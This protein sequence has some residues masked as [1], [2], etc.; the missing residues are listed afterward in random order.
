MAKKQNMRSRSGIS[1]PLMHD[2][3]KSSGISVPLMH[4]N[5]LQ[6]HK[7][8]YLP[9]WRREI[10]SYS[11]NFRLAD[12]LPQHILHSIKDEREELMS[13]SKSKLGLNKEEQ[14][15]LEY[16]FSE[17]IE[18][19]LN[20]GKGSCWLKKDK[21]ASCAANAINYFEEER[22]K[23]FAW[24]VMPNHI[25]V[26]LR[27]Y[28]KY[29]LEKTLHSWKSFIAKESN[30][31]L[32]RSGSFWVKESY[33]HLIRNEQELFHHINYTW[34]NPD[35]AGLEN[36]KWRWKISDEELEEYLFRP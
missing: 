16:L 35:K 6:I 22:Y 28:P 12:S 20:M 11:V 32:N 27:T 36:W 23:L 25:H 19:Y 14:Q 17:K 31:I 26:V 30:K 5:E 4:D 29:P 21:I 24:C 9:H 7:G 1:V 2:N 34:N 8:S 10:A 15:R 33:D 3:E 18:N 13:A